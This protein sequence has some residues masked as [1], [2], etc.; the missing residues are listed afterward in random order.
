MPDKGYIGYGYKAHFAII[1]LNCEGNE[2]TFGTVRPQPCVQATGFL[3]L[4]SHSYK[5]NRQI[6]YIDTDEVHMCIHKGGGA[7]LRLRETNFV[8]VAFDSLN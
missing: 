8:Q 4:C 3:G 5:I 1:I 2:P 7:L 6:R